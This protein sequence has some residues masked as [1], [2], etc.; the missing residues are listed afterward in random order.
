MLKAIRHVQRRRAD[1]R[2]AID[3]AASFEAWEETCVPSY[4]HRNWAAAGISWLRLFVARRMAATLAMP[5]SK[6]LDFGASVGEMGHL[7]QEIGFKYHFIELDEKAATFLQSRLPAARRESLEAAPAG[8]FD[9]I[10]AIDSLEHNDDFEGL[11]RQLATKLTPEGVL[12]LSGP[13]ENFL[14]RLGRAIAG[15]HGHY[16]HA[17]IFDIERA[18]AKHFSLRRVARVLPLLTLFRV[19]AWQRR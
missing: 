8:S 16:H 4:C 13:T 14:Y 3:L 5:G 1:L 11:L 15:F 17:T 18:A 6:V 19:T 10:F 12:I 2:A 7:V 9:V